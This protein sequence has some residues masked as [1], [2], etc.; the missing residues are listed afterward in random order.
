MTPNSFT[1]YQ[2]LFG[3]TQASVCQNSEVENIRDLL[4]ITGKGG[5]GA[6]K[7]EGA[8]VSEVLP[9]REGG[10]VNVL[11]MLKGGGGSQQ[12]LA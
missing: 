4:L 9:L 2:F 3:V 8:G 1:F 11:A 5:G 6:T 10:V 12:V 7:Q